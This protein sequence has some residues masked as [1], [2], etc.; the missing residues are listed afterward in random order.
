MIHL[1]ASPDELT[2]EG[3]A[4]LGR[5]RVAHSFLYASERRDAEFRLRKTG[6]DAAFRY[7]CQRPRRAARIPA[8]PAR[9]HKRD[10]GWYLAWPFAV[11]CGFWPLVPEPPHEDEPV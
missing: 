5:D 2:D 4:W 3:R 6:A 8:R 11:L 7:L 1:S 9:P 10:I